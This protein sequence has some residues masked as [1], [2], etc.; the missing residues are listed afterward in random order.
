MLEIYLLCIEF[1]LETLA[2]RLTDAAGGANREDCILQYAESEEA[3]C[4]V[5]RALWQLSFHFER[6]WISGEQGLE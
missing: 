6:L 1:A 2:W 5:D 3:G 4:V